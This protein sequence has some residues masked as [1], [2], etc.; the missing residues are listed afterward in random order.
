MWSCFLPLI[1]QIYHTLLLNTRNRTL[2]IADVGQRRRRLLELHA[3]LISLHVG[4]N[5]PEA[6]SK[7][8]MSWMGNVLGWRV[9]PW[10]FV[11]FY[12]SKFLPTKFSSSFSDLWSLLCIFCSGGCSHEHLVPSP[13]P[14]V[15]SFSSE[16]QTKHPE[17]VSWRSGSQ[18]VS[19]SPDQQD[20]CGW[21]RWR[22][23]I[24]PASG[25]DPPD[26]VQS[27]PHSVPWPSTWWESW[28][29]VNVTF[30]EDFGWLNVF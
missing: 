7:F 14:V 11:K 25:P 17:L 26:V 30:D 4:G 3:E 23:S 29:L 22:F 8:S 2:L 19:S 9:I 13:R 5:D 24:C 20:T 10:C 27:S 6:V 28:H 15:F 16:L 21:G 12:I 18:L 1:M